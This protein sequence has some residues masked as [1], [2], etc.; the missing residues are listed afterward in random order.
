MTANNFMAAPPVFS[1][2]NYHIWEVKMKSYLEACE[3]WDVVENDQIQPLP[4]DP[5]LKAIRNQR[6]EVKK[7]PKPRPAFA[8]LYLMKF[9][10]VS[11][12]VSQ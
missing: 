3:L 9:S 2:A 8:Q 1:G 10:Q 7:K 5:T 4:E 6:N 11:W 12:L